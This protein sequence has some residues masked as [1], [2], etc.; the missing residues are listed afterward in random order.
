MKKD[1][2]IWKD[3]EIFE[4]A[5]AISSKLA[6]VGAAAEVVASGRGTS[7]DLDVPKDSS[8]SSALFIC[9]SA[10]FEFAEGGETLVEF[11]LSVASSV[12]SPSCLMLVSGASLSEADSLGISPFWQRRKRGK[13]DMALHSLPILKVWKTQKITHVKL[14]GQRKIPEA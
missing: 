12:S 6:V 2:I 3:R 7:A 8:S 11:V 4:L 9:F 13:E 10:S 1:C 5:I 14:T